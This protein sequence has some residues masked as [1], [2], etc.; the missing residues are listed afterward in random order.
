MACCWATIRPRPCRTDCSLWAQRRCTRRGSS[1]GRPRVDHS[2]R[3][4]TTKRPGRGTRIVAARLHAT[5]HVPDD[6]QS[7]RALELPVL[8]AGLGRAA[9]RRV[10]RIRGELYFYESARHLFSKDPNRG[11]SI[12]AIARR[13]GRSAA[14]RRPRPARPDVPGVLA[15]PGTLA[16]RGLARKEQPLR[17]HPDR[18][19]SRLSPRPSGCSVRRQR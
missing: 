2:R 17:G 5:R 13:L 19:P 10:A 16:G 9:D 18:A 6:D 3:P 12:L 4:E 7:R 14:S 8:A 1:R 15:V 11:G